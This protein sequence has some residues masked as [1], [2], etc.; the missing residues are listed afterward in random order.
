MTIYF[1]EIMRKRQ[2]DTHTP[3]DTYVFFLSPTVLHD[4]SCHLPTNPREQSEGAV[5]T[6][7]GATVLVT[8][9]LLLLLSWQTKLNRPR[10]IWYQFSHKSSHTSPPRPGH[11]NVCPY[12]Q[13][14]GLIRHGRSQARSGYIAPQQQA[15]YQLGQ[16]L[17]STA[18][19]HQNKY[20]K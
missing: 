1:L 14:K 12:G 9:Q 4:T 20:A 8:Q 11:G 5:L 16:V 3:V 17:E 19:R 2:T 10:E 6:G 13:Q 7:A 18:H 15:Q